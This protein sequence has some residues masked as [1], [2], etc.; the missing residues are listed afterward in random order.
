[1]AASTIIGDYINDVMI[2]LDINDMLC[3][4]DMIMI[5][6]LITSGIFR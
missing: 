4:N 6:M 3:D 1:M 5:I 2:M